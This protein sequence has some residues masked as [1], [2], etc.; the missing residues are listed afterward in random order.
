MQPLYLLRATPTHGAKNH[1]TKQSLTLEFSAPVLGFTCRRGIQLFR[2][3]E[4][5]AGVEEP[6]P[7]SF[8]LRSSGR[9][10]HVR[11]AEGAL[12]TGHV[13][14]LRLTS[15]LRRAD[16]A[17][18]NQNAP[19]APASP[20]ERFG[21]EGFYQAVFATGA[22]RELAL[23]LDENLPAAGRR[24]VDLNAA[25]H[26]ELV[27]LPGMT[28]TRATA[29]VARRTAAGKFADFPDV[30]KVPGI[31]ESTLR[32]MAGQAAL[33]GTSD[34]GAAVQ[35]NRG[36]LVEVVDA[37]RAQ[38]ETGCSL[39]GDVQSGT[40]AEGADRAWY[41]T[42]TRS[43]T[44]VESVQLGL[45]KVLDRWPVP[46]ASD[47]V[48]AASRPALFLRGAGANQEERLIRVGT[49]H[50]LITSWP[51]PLKPLKLERGSKATSGTRPLCLSQD[52]TQ[53]WM[54]GLQREVSKLV[55]FDLE[56]GAVVRNVRLD[57]ALNVS[58]IFRSATRGYAWLFARS[59]GPGLPAHLVEFDVAGR[60]EVRRVALP[61]ETSA[62]VVMPDQTQVVAACGQR[63]L[64]V[65]LAGDSAPRLLARLVGRIVSLRLDV[66]TG[67]IY[68]LT[69]LR[70]TRRLHCLRPG[71]MLADTILSDRAI[72]EILPVGLNVVYPA[73]QNNFLTIFNPGA[74]RAGITVHLRH[75]GGGYAGFSPFSFSV[76]AGSRG[77]V[78]LDDHL[79]AHGGFS[80]EIDA[81]RPVVCERSSYWAHALHP[82][83]VAAPALTPRPQWY[84][85][86]GFRHPTF[87]NALEV[88]NPGHASTTVTVHLLKDRE[89]A[90]LS[91]WP[92][93][94]ELAG[95][96]R[97]RLDLD[98]YLP[99][100]ELGFGL[101]VVATSPVTVERSMYWLRGAQSSTGMPAPATSAYFAGGDTR[102]GA[103]TFVLLAA[104]SQPA[105]VQLFLRDE[106]GRVLTPGA[107]PL[108]VEVAAGRRNTVQLIEDLVGRRRFS[109]ELRSSAPLVAELS[110]YLPDGDGYAVPGEATGRAEWYFS[111]GWTGGD[112]RPTLCVFNPSARPARLSISAPGAD[113]A[114]QGGHG[115]GMPQL[116]LPAFGSAEVELR[117]HIAPERVFGLVVRSDVPVVV[118]REMRWRE[119][120]AVA[121][122]AVPSPP[123]QH[124]SLTGGSHVPPLSADRRLDINQSTVA[125]LAILPVVGPVKAQAIVDYRRQ[126]GRFTDELELLDVPGFGGPTYEAV[127]GL[128]KVE[129]KSTLRG[130]QIA[131]PPRLLDVEL[132]EP[133]IGSGFVES[134]EGSD[135]FEE[136]ISLPQADILSRVTEDIHP[137]T[138]NLTVRQVDVKLPGRA[139]LGFE[140]A[141]L[142]DTGALFQG[143]I[144]PRVNG[145]LHRRMVAV[146]AALETIY[147]GGVQEIADARTE[148]ATAIV[149]ATREANT[150]AEQT[151]DAAITVALE[152]ARR[153]IADEVNA[154]KDEAAAELESELAELEA[155]LAEL[156]DDEPDEGDDDGE[157]EGDPSELYEEAHEEWEQEVQE[158]EEE[159]QQKQEEL[160]ELMGAE[161]PEWQQDDYDAWQDRVDAL[162]QDVEEIEDALQALEDDEPQREDFLE[163]GDEDEGEADE[164]HDEWQEAV[165][166]LEESI[167]EVEQALAD[168]DD[169]IDVE[170]I[171][172][173]FEDEFLRDA[174]EQRAEVIREALAEFQREMDEEVAT[175]RAEIERIEAELRQN[176]DDS[177]RV[178][179]STLAAAPGTRQPLP[180]P[181]G[182]GWMFDLPTYHVEQKLLHPG[183]GAL[184]PVAWNDDQFT[185]PGFHLTLRRLAREVPG[186]NG[187]PRRASYELEKELY[188]YLDELGLPLALTDRARVNWVLFDWVRTQAGEPQLALVRGAAGDRVELFY[189]GS[190]LERLAW[191]NGREL[192]FSYEQAA[193][194]WQL[195]AVTDSLNRT[196]SYRYDEPL[197]VTSQSWRLS[198]GLLSLVKF[199]GRGS[200]GYHYDSRPPAEPIYL[201][202]VA[203]D[204]KRVLDEELQFNGPPYV[205]NQYHLDNAGQT[206]LSVSYAYSQPQKAL[207][208]TVINEPGRLTRM[209]FRAPLDAE[210]EPLRWNLAEVRVWPAQDGVPEPGPPAHSRKLTT[211]ALGNVTLI[212][213]ARQGVPSLLT[214][215]AY[216]GE[217][218]SHGR[219]T[220]VTFRTPGGETL[221]EIR[222][223][224]HPVY[225]DQFTA[226]EGDVAPKLYWAYDEEGRDPAQ[227]GRPTSQTVYLGGQPL[228]TKY[229]YDEFGNLTEITGPDGRA[230]TQIYAP[231]NGVAA[232]TL[233]E[234]REGLARPRVWR[235]ETHPATGW[236]LGMVQPDG[237]R[238]KY[239]R[240]IWGRITAI[241]DPLGRRAAYEYR[242]E[243]AQVVLKKPGAALL[244]MT[245]D[246][247]GRVRRRELFAAP[248]AGGG[249]GPVRTIGYT[250]DAWGNLSSRTDTDGTVTTWQR[251][252]GGRPLSITYPDQSTRRWQ[253]DDRL[254][255]RRLGE[256]TVLATLVRELDQENAPREKL[257]DALN[258]E[259][260]Q[261]VT[262]GDTTPRFAATSLE[263]NRIGQLVRMRAPRGGVERYAYDELGRLIERVDAAGGI[264]RS[265]YYP[266]GQ[267]K[268]LTEAD[269]G[270]TSWELDE[271]GRVVAETDP[272]GN[273]ARYT[274]DAM[275]RIREA[276]D[277]VGA[278]W[279]LERNAAGEVE[280]VTD[281]AGGRTT[282]QYDAAGRLVRMTD[283]V[284]A[285]ARYVY[286]GFGDLLE[287][288][289]A[290]DE[291][292]RY[293]RAPDGRVMARVDRAGGRWSMEYDL[294]GRAKAGVN[295]LGQRTEYLLNRR[296][297]LDAVRLHDGQRVTFERDRVGR[298]LRRVGPGSLHYER[299]LDDEGNVLKESDGDGVTW[300]YEYDLAGRVSKSLD[301]AGRTTEF[302]WSPGGRLLS[303]KDARGGVWR[304][305]YDAAGRLRRSINP[306]GVKVEI[307]YDAAGR[308]VAASLGG[309]TAR[310]AY[311]GRGMLASETDP[312]GLKRFFEYDAAGR[313]TAAWKRPGEATRFQLDALGRI[314]SVSDA[315]G[316]RSSYRYG[317]H[318]Q[319]TQ[320]VDPLG[321]AVTYERDVL[322][323][324]VAVTNQLGAK[325]TWSYDEQERRVGMLDELRRNWLYAYD[326]A[327]RLE[328]IQ[329]PSGSTTRMSWTDGG[330]LRSITDT[331]GSTWLRTYD[332]LGLLTGVEDP[333]ALTTRY[334]YDAGGLLVRLEEPDGRGR[335][336]AY[337]AAGRLSTIDGTEGRIAAFTYNAQSQIVRVEGRNGSVA[338]DFDDA[339][340]ILSVTK[341]DAPVIVYGYDDRGLVQK[342]EVGERA[343]LYTHNRAEQ[344]VE[345]VSPESVISVERDALGRIKSRSSS[346]GAREVVVFDP[347]GRLSSL[348]AGSIRL[349][350]SYDAAGNLVEERREGEPQPTRY[351]YDALDQLVRVRPAAGGERSL[352]YDRAG[353][354]TQESADRRGVRRYTYSRGHRLLRVED[355]LTGTTHEVEHDAAGRITALPDA[356]GRRWQLRYDDAGALVE[357]RRVGA[358]GVVSWQRDALS[359][360]VGRSG[361]DGN[362]RL[363]VADSGY[364][365]WS[366]LSTGKE[367]DWTPQGGLDGYAARK[368]SERKKSPETMSVQQPD[369]TFLGHLGAGGTTTAAQ[370]LGP[371][372]ERAATEST[373]GV[374][375]LGFAGRPVC[376]ESGIVDMR[377]RPY[378]PWLGRFL[379]PDPLLGALSDPR[380]RNP[381]VLAGNNPLRRRD[382]LGLDWTDE[383]LRD[384]DSYSFEYES[385]IFG[386]SFSLDMATEVTGTEW[387]DW[388][389]YDRI[390]ED[391]RVSDRIEF[392]PN[393]VFD[394]IEPPSLPDINVNLDVSEMIDHVR[395]TQMQVVHEVGIDILRT[396]L[397][398]T[399]A[400]V[401]MVAGAAWNLA[402]M[403]KEGAYQAIDLMGAYLEN[404]S[405]HT[406]QHQMWSNLGKAA[407]AGWGTTDML[408]GMA[409]N[410]VTSFVTAPRNAIEA[411]RRG[412]YFNFGAELS[413]VYLTYHPMAVRA[414][415]RVVSGLPHTPGTWGNAV[416]TFVRNTQLKAIA[417]SV[418]AKYRLYGYTEKPAGIVYGGPNLPGKT[419]TASYSPDTR[420]VTV[421]ERAFT[422]SIST[423]LSSPKLG[424]HYNPGARMFWE[425]LLKGNSAY[426]SL[427]HEWWHNIQNQAKQAWYDVSGA[428]A[429]LPYADRPVEFTLHPAQVANGTAM[430][431]AH[432]MAARM[433]PLQGFQ[434]QLVLFVRELFVPD[435]GEQG[436]D[437]S[438]WPD[439]DDG[440]H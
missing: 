57:G 126:H 211:D 151:Y 89:V 87:R 235:L 321:H 145:E 203:A 293:E 73:R 337:D 250:Y 156:L 273:R 290:L 71:A 192:R 274:L 101:R 279:L 204:G 241:T 387:I 41:L 347:V 63:L 18:F 381:Y 190:R 400:L 149:E 155:D 234:Y 276:F 112:F 188:W 282:Y 55:A 242:D 111:E 53:V 277:P 196:V 164:A 6:L 168:L 213:E 423:T 438:M 95:R 64:S 12:R 376:P 223:S 29:L 82:M 430:A 315:E 90:G 77:T 259:L 48:M 269:G 209:T 403:L 130:I 416:K 51:V 320:A 402:G 50:G 280:R 413:N 266:G 393:F 226:L 435:F 8:R 13:Y 375:P 339:G 240:D 357:A 175:V 437:P 348:T 140:L 302:G 42:G 379:T 38:V 124:I 54:V 247:L 354:R 362:E 67:F 297:E 205:Y 298:V 159:L 160:E 330:R 152:E 251:D 122:L 33:L 352:L 343:L 11:A 230:L 169:E 179:D 104:P 40:W 401:Q 26:D 69:S 5:R 411:A 372:G 265:S 174:N 15:A 306:L 120:Q 184:L 59:K 253:Y 299:V 163:G 118:H 355:L 335:T 429:G 304:S 127:R 332:A 113:G 261:T 336:Y 177:R 342:V 108:T 125:R 93:K 220:R 154:A 408:T 406:Y 58:S 200:Y 181:L 263:Y 85:A 314:L 68:A 139:Q 219:P 186:T 170:Q 427:A 409:V 199:P 35:V 318:D 137:H 309:A 201:P 420:I 183:G 92:L 252:W 24:L 350:R 267:L 384:G 405:L 392:D 61:P 165:E 178:I 326:A 424:P 14:L 142:Y 264:E 425:T 147:R 37:R 162:E 292:T 4:L 114:E 34:V 278:R 233:A 366:Q 317:P 116:N 16:G 70:G 367:I 397:D 323:R 305:S 395:E 17:R 283:A 131:T 327:G 331:A 135:T 161:P 421:F 176:Y 72:G 380:R 45:P 341:P 187:E 281:P 31:G 132:P 324:L 94:L 246:G 9:R 389:D 52:E 340:R 216:E 369:A 238:V 21:E 368:V 36:R 351:T 136:F 319:M 338:M 428:R 134:L 2:F 440:N 96:E 229:R 106:A 286:D 412:D 249:S 117:E 358:A 100:E 270:T 88:F 433:A 171:L 256:R 207:H 303:V 382:P 432:N 439:D 255:Q 417:K 158:T 322:G 105:T 359:N 258:Q 141:R 27:R 313:M 133:T 84:F 415:N 128:V 300:Q 189:T 374:E 172:R 76:A 232:A 39:G 44:F 328:T 228:V 349:N 121:A 398:A 436:Y 20:Y 294:L 224:Y 407:E 148:L 47:L 365:R 227:L 426:K 49:V 97:R 75:E 194:F 268:S 390:M 239:E 257:F 399:S 310:W 210:G 191:S 345:I 123:A 333:D 248:P 202:L 289:N 344:L 434:A 102:E 1:S 287:E 311:D 254:M 80:C 119:G 214:G 377:A 394:D 215:M 74:Q 43:Q 182:V 10:V 364:L 414:F 46:A 307:E 197:E 361:A 296:G 157:L 185:P 370:R 198:A 3:D 22:P 271:W 373:K 66:Q 91:S 212:E 410:F 110:V 422:R 316:H 98:Q 391:A 143:Q 346:T 129:R 56:R 109:V 83:G 99:D 166:E 138:G 25:G 419:S 19:N 208:E 312:T 260:G 103:T 236:L 385:D 115:A 275:D 78:R 23:A 231:R 146:R 285:T 418:Q 262:L 360:V 217:Q 404:A 86:E 144:V 383:Q 371:F 243:S 107:E 388:S 30:L 79:V 180:L 218:A 356:Q 222:Y 173:E 295:P 334:Q 167:D 206:A 244:V 245:D 153:E 221:R 65:A 195:K 396:L 81:D 193:D 301:G 284:G 237:Q 308:Q 32:E 62:A 386:D 288:R 353:N 7:V 60:A 329:D 378:A 325:R 431:G 28:A 150:I 291:T 225:K 363:L 272:T